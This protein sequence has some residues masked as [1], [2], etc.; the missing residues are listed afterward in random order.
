MV[1]QHLERRGADRAG[2]AEKGQPA[3]RR[4]G[5]HDPSY[6]ISSPAAACSKPP[7]QAPRSAAAQAAAINPSAR[8]RTPPCPGMRLP[9]SLVSQAR[10]AADSKRSPA[11]SIAARAPLRSPMAASARQAGQLG[12]D[13]TR[14]GA[15][16]DRSGKARP[17]LVRRHGGGKARTADSPAGEIGGAVG[18]PDHGEDQENGG[19]PEDRVATQGDEGERRQRHIGNAED[20]PGAQLIARG[21]DAPEAHRPEQADERQRPV[22]TELQRD[23]RRQHGAHDMDHGLA[24][25]VAEHHAAPFERRRQAEHH[26]GKLEPDAAEPGDQQDGRRQHGGGEAAQSKI[27]PAGDDIVA[28]QWRGHRIGYSALAVI[29]PKRRSRC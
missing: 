15:G 11:C 18:G 25:I 7:R 14:Q 12:D 29:P 4:R 2:G 10:L 1:R 27:A 13:Q 26:G 21:P 3:G 20:P 19:E 28:C 23:R 9:V 6:H 5:A 17:G 8:S 24:A 22:R 16:N